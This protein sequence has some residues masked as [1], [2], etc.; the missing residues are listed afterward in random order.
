MKHHGTLIAAASAKRVEKH[1]HGRR[2]NVLVPNF[3][4]QPFKQF[5]HI[6]Y[7]YIFMDF[8]KDKYLW[9]VKCEGILNEIS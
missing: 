2:E 8:L 9:R 3:V 4:L 1:L 5:I 6:P 7:L